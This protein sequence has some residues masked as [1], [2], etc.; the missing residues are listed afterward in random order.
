MTKA[1]NA[2]EVTLAV[3]GKSI[4]AGFADG[5]FILIEP[6]NPKIQTA[7]GTDGEVTVSRDPRKSAVITVSLMSTSDGNDVFQDMVDQMDS[8][9]GIALRSLTIKDGNGRSLHEGDCIVQ[10]PPPKGYDRVAGPVQWKLFVPNLRHQ[11]RGNRRA[12]VS[13]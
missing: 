2:D 12:T 7:E 1:Y 3:G 11:V 4:E 5:Q 10:D 13:G 8:G 6:R 9:A